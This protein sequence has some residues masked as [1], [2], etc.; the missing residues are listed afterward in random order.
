MEWYSWRFTAAPVGRVIVDIR[1]ACPAPDASSTSLPVRTTRARPRAS[2]ILLALDGRVLRLAPPTAR[3]VTAPAPGRWRIRAAG[4][5]HAVDLEAWADEADAHALPVPVP[6]ERR[7]EPRSR[8]H[9]AG[10]VAVTL[11]R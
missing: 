6:D 9:L 7:A 4:P 3:V 10:H 1:S 8:Q 5:R 2:A 11:R